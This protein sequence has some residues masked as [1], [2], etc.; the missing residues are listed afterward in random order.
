MRIRNNKDN[1]SKFASHEEKRKAILKYSEMVLEGV[2]QKEICQ[3]LHQ[4][5]GFNETQALQFVNEVKDTI[6][7]TTAENNEKIIEIHTMIY[8][9]VYRRFGKLGL[10]SGKMKAMAQKEK[11]LNL[12][13]EDTTEVVMNT[14][15]NINIQTHYD[16]S[17]LT[18]QQQSR[19][20]ELL[21]KAK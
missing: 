15:N 5:I 13:Q 16:V 8:E 14:Q 18:P 3:L 4:E 6:A 11:L 2:A 17:K 1:P 19:L 9:D 12:Y 20:D 21:L 7:E 10:A